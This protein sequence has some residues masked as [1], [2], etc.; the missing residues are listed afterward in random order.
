MFNVSQAKAGEPAPAI[1]CP[2]ELPLSLELINHAIAGESAPAI[3]CPG[4][5][6]LS[7]EP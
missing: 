6:A 2:G 5:L 3:S 4:E 7:L 1:S